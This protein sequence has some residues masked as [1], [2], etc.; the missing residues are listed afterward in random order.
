VVDLSSDEEDLFLDSLRDEEFTMKLFGNL[1]HAL[2][3]PPG[4]GNII[5]LSDSDKEEEA[6]E[7]DVTDVDAAPPSAVKSMALTASAADADNVL[8]G[9]QNDNSDGG[10]EADSP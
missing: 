6:R 5:V 10:D 2:L 4:D 1:N 7:E 8:E 3:G 9:V